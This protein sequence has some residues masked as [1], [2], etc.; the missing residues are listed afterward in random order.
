M[1]EDKIQKKDKNTF[2]SIFV[3]FTSVIGIV[4]VVLMVGVGFNLSETFKLGREMSGLEAR[5]ADTPKKLSTHTETLGTLN[6]ELKITKKDID[7][8]MRNLEGIVS[9][10]SEYK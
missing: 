1:A 7:D 3:I 2:M 6:N 10:L 5:L 4:L 9:D 8:N